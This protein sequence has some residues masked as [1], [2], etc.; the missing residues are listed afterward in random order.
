MWLNSNRPGLCQAA[1]LIRFSETFRPWT[2]ARR[3]FETLY[4]CNLVAVA[5]VLRNVKLA[6][7]EHHG[8][9][10]R[11]WPLLTWLW[12]SWTDWRESSFGVE[13]SHYCGNLIQSTYGHV[14]ASNE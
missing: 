2:S 5:K 3:S 13:G 6:H 9:W 7:L 10:S 14:W 1:T 11:K 8:K 4:R 12:I